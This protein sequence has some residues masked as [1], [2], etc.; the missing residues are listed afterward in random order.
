MDATNVRGYNLLKIE[1]LG[2]GNSTV[3]YIGGSSVS[4]SVPGTVAPRVPGT[5]APHVP[6]G[7]YSR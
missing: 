6:P 7:P 3:Q 4:T 1:T 5:V 2:D